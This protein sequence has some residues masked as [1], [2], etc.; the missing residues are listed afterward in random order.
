[1]IS[2]AE[3]LQLD[4]QAR[5]LAL[6]R[7]VKSILSFMDKLILNLKINSAKQSNYLAASHNAYNAIKARFTSFSHTNPYDADDA[8]AAEIT[9]GKHDKLER[10][11]EDNLHAALGLA[12]DSLEDKKVLNIDKE[13]SSLITEL[14][15]HQND[16]DFT[17]TTLPLTRDF[18]AYKLLEVLQTKTEDD[19][20]IRSA[21]DLA[22]GTFK[23]LENPKL[24][25]DIYTKANEILATHVK[26]ETTRQ[27]MELSL[28]VFKEGIEDGSSS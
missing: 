26:D 18:Y 2:V 15:K 4:T 27:R 24:V 28:A 5:Y 9:P 14:E 23:H 3:T 7:T 13:K 11:L 21:A 22:H 17:S 8:D 16:K 10:T 1:M 20:G 25:N 19:S 6:P 12:I